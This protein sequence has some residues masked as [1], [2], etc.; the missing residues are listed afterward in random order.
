MASKKFN[1]LT[2]LSPLVLYNIPVVVL[3]FGG[4]MDCN[5]CK[6]I[7]CTER[8][9][10]QLKNLLGELPPH[11][12]HKYNKQVFHHHNGFVA[13]RKHNSYLYPCDECLKEN[14][15]V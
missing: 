8:E 1:K 3:F 2:N 4:F 10:H 14:S 6:H 12:C 9:Q 11:I 5:E 7:S 15:E 13:G